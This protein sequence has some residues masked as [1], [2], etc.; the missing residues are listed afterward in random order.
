MQLNFFE[1]V[2]KVKPRFPAIFNKTNFKLD[3][4]IISKVR[5]TV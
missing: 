4:L 2:I 5:V 3:S 1:N